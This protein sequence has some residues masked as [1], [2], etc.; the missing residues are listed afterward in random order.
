MNPG[1]S[2]G[3]GGGEGSLKELRGYMFVVDRIM[4]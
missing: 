1:N 4:S 3:W 2:V